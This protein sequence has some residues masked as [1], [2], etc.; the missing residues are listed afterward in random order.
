MA[1]LPHEVPKLAVSY[2]ANEQ[3]FATLLEQ[4]LKRV[5]EVKLIENK[6]QGK[7]E[8]RAPTVHTVDRRFRRI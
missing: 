6:P 2:E 7:V 8:T 4:R 1:A 3:D 5:Q